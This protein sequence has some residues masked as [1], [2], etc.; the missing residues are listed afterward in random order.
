M[1]DKDVTMMIISET[2]DLLSN[3]KK[4]DTS[5]EDYVKALV[6][7]AN[8]IRGDLDK[9]DSF[10][11]DTCLNRGYIMKATRSD[12]G[13]WHEVMIEC[14]CMK[15]RRAINLMQKSGLED[16][17][18][19]CR[20]SN[21]EITEDW[22]KTILKVAQ[23]YAKQPQ[24]WFFIGGQPGAGKTHLCTAIARKLL[25]KNIEVRYMLW[26]DE[27]SKIKSSFGDVNL[28]AYV[29]KLKTVECL[30]I[31]DL[32]KAPTGKAITDWEIEQAFEI[33][34]AR[35]SN[36][37]LITIISSEKTLKEIISVDEAIGS[38]IAEK[39]GKNILNV[40]KDTQKNYRLKGMI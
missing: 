5:N 12:A 6:N 2:L 35:Y 8:G 33:V 24:G 27:I 16:K 28:P 18:K 14:K 40:E 1:T 31:D 30:Y 9:A 36:P 17:I 15:A 38:R 11:C 21:F 7:R 26:R 22:Q 32:F 25:L 10:N 34:N 23:E 3:A 37:G 29:G 19:K 20:F 39:S 13:L 4:A